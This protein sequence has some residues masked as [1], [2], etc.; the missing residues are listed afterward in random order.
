[1]KRPRIASLEDPGRTID[2]DTCMDELQR[3]FQVR[4][5]CYD[6][7]IAEGKLSYSDARDRHQRLRAAIAHLAALQCLPAGAE[8]PVTS[9]GDDAPPF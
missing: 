7:W 6:R 5:R 2:L 8:D 9:S 1:V 3:E 4:L